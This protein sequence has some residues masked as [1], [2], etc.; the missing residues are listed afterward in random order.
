VK[1]TNRAARSAR[2]TG[3]AF[4]EFAIVAPILALVMFAI[5]ELGLMCGTE[6]E[7]TAVAREGARSAASGE[8]ST[9]IA[10]RGAAVCSA[11]P[12]AQITYVLQY[13]AY[14]GDSGWDTTWVTLGTSGSVNSAPM[15]AQVRC[16]ALYDYKLVMPAMFRFLATDETAGT[17]RLV[18]SVTMTRA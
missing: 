17:V 2:R 16:R 12:P 10:D 4:V 9:A 13:R 15:N 6:M 14:L 8:V 11:I 1:L 18:G 5:L 3:T 7:L